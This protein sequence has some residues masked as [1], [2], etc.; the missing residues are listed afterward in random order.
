VKIIPL[1]AIFEAAHT[2]VVRNIATVARF[3]SRWPKREDSPTYPEAAVH[4]MPSCL[5]TGLSAL[6][7]K[8]VVK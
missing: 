2:F 8:S 6:S 1:H 3:T 4:K 7:V 5:N